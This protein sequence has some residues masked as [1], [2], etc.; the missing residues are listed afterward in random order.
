[1]SINISLK[2]I[3]KLAI[4]A[5]IAG[6]SEPILSITDTAIVGN[7]NVNATESLAAVGIVGAFISMLIWVL[8]QTRSAISSIVSQYVGANKLEKIKNLPAQA[9]F[10]ITSLSILIILFTYPFAETIFKLYNASNLILEYSVDYYKIRVFGFPFTLF[11]IAVFGT[12]RGLQNTYYPMVIAIIGA[13]T[14]II[15]D[16]ILVFGIQNYIPAMNIKGA[17]YASLAAQCLMALLSAYYLLKK[18]SIPLKLSFPLNKEINRFIIMI[19]NLFIRTIALN[20]TLYFATRFATGYGAAYIAAYT[21]SINLW[22]FCAFFIDGYASAGNI[23]SGKLLGA[24]TYSSLLK[25]SNKL[26]KYGIIIGISLAIMGAIFYFPLGQLFSKDPEVLNLFYDS[27]WI[28][29]IMQPLCAIAF[30]FDGIFKGLGEMKHLR[31]VLMFSTFIV[32]IPILFWLDSLG[33]KL[34]GIFIA[35]TFWIIAR[36]IPLIVKFRKTFTKLSEND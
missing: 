14:N 36:G 13:L 8:G 5:L 10:I 34:H 6:I 25:L 33:Y 32:F 9:I 15:L 22:F 1:M 2:H 30:I 27:F 29:L 3:N 26:M 31:N 16:Y 11:T 28:I 21:I 12:F 35:L 23:L 17:A 20:T 24:K 18:T 4:P 19:L 7:I